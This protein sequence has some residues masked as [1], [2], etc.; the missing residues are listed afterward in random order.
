VA[1]SLF[2]AAAVVAAF[3]PGIGFGLICAALILHLKPD[4]G[5]GAQRGSTTER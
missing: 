1:L 2:A 5:Y 4:I 3:Q